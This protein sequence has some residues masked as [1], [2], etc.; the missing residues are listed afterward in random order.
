M[1]A[2]QAEMFDEEVQEDKTFR[3]LGMARAPDHGT[4]VMAAGKVERK[5]SDLQEWIV[6][7]LRA[8]GPMTDRELEQLPEFIMYAP[9]TV[10]KRR[11][12]LW[13]DGRG[14]LV[15]DGVKD[16]LTIWKLIEGA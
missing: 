9:S 13:D 6:C 11:S 4:S 10:R 15:R 5:R 2:K 7:A 14:V 16:G 8:N 1:T 12:E 3:I